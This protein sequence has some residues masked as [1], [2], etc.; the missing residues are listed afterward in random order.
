MISDSV[1]IK[2]DMIFKKISTVI[3]VR[4]IEKI[5]AIND[6][7]VEKTIDTNVSSASIKTFNTFIYF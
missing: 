7:I 6:K 5:A 3:W 2:A 4:M 1:I